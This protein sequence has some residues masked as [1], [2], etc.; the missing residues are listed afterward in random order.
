MKHL[1]PNDIRDGLNRG[2]VR[3]QMLALAAEIADCSA[4]SDIESFCTPVEEHDVRWWD[5]ESAGC[6]GNYIELAE[7]YLDARGL[8]LRH[9]PG[10]PMLVRFVEASA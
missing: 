3:F 9:S 10:K 7:R 6:D 5:L 4:R 2:T 1:S 8:L